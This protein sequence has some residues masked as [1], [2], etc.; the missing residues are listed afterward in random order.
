V[1]IGV[2][3]VGRIGAIHAG[4]LAGLP[5]VD[6]VVIADADPARARE[7]A[8]ELA[9]PARI[10]VATGTAHLLA[11]GVDGLV[12]AAATD[13]H[14]SLTHDGIA[15][16]VPVFC[17]KPVARDLVETIALADRIEG[18]GAYVQVGFQRRF[19]VGY[20]AARAAVRSGELGWVHTM[21]AGTLDAAPPPAAYIASSGG[22][23][24]DCSVHDLDIVAWV[25]GR[26]IVE[27]YARGCN[28]GAA[29][30]AAAGDVDAAAALVSLDDG[31]FAH[32]AAGRYN[33]RGYDVRLEVLGSLDSI[34]VGLDDQLPLRSVQPGVGFPSGP[35]VQTFLDRFAAAY[36]AELRAFVARVA[37]GG[38][39][40]CTVRDAVAATAAAEAC[41]LSRAEHRPVGLAE[42]L[43]T[44]AVAAEAVR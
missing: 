29:F 25:T 3:G 26:E 20:V 32:L 38:P 24:R 30:F 17:E 27:V 36:T 37:D 2:A 13:A 41:E 31:S 1:R 23:F 40:P 39:S 42:V 33:A 12:V 10:E 8:T 19:D 28:H 14:L 7:V 43:A 9:G 34:A 6:T 21:R 4:T 18:T 22:L 5:E 11:S 35:P 44:A 15:A 16:G